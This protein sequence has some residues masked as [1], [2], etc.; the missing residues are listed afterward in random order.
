MDERSANNWTNSRFRAL[1][2]AMALLGTPLSSMRAQASPAS[3]AAWTSTLRSGSLQQRADA[4]AHLLHSPVSALPPDT[5]DAFIAELNRLHVALV[6]GTPLTSP[7]QGELFT[8]YYMSLVNTVAELRTPEAALALAPAVAVSGGVAR[9]VARLGDAGVDAVL[10]LLARRYE[11]SS[12]LETLGLAWFWADSAHAALSDLSRAHIVSAFTAFAASDSVDNILGMVAVLRNTADPA[13]LP[14]ATS[15][16]DR[17]DT[18]GA[19]EHVAA[20]Y[21]RTMVIPDLTARAAAMST[22]SFVNAANR[23]LQAICTPTSPGRRNGACESMTNDMARAR[24]FIAA[25]QLRDAR[26]ALATLSKHA[27]NGFRADGLQEL[28]YK[29]IAGDA[30]LIA[31]RLGQ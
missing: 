2:L 14:L 5:R 4:L 19:A 25:G 17:V 18:L 15:M 12:M 16:R 24:R 6:A 9:R 13:F 20:S 7:D 11:V 31:A 27:E 23:I 22:A 21:I 3:I 30:E 8:D 1:G 10:P 28:E 26:T 29:L